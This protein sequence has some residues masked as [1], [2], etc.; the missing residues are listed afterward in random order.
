[1]VIV[2]VAIWPWHGRD[3]SRQPQLGNMMKTWVIEWASALE[4]PR[5]GK[6]HRILH[7]FL[8][9]SEQ[10]IWTLD[11]TE[12]NTPF[13]LHYR[14]GPWDRSFFGWGRT[15]NPAPFNRVNSLSPM[16]LIIELSPLPAEIV[17]QNTP[18]SV[19]QGLEEREG[20]G[21]RRG[22]MFGFNAGRNER[23]G[24]IPSHGVR[25]VTS[26]GVGFL[27]WALYRGRKWVSRESR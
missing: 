10:G 19:S 23:F 15:M 1:M 16:R 2:V 4:V 9:A 17:A 3:K 12:K 8:L 26:K 18:P 6:I 14:R 22:P 5:C 27:S 25:S 24:S 21:S 13:L 7:A 11:G 20:Q